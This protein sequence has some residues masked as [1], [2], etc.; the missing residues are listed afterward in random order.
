MTKMKLTDKEIGSVAAII[1]NYNGYEDTEACINSIQ[2]IYGDRL[3]IYLIDNA[4]TDGS[5]LKLKKKFSAVSFYELEENRGYAAGNNLGI[6]KAL[7]DGFKNFLVL[8]NDI[9]LTEDVLTPFL[10]EFHSDPQTGI[11]T[12]K[13]FFT[14]PEKI[15]YSAGGRFNRWICT[16]ENLKIGKADD[17]ISER[18]IIDFFPGAIFLI[19]KEVVDNVGFMKEHFFMYYEDLEYSFRVNQMYKMVYFSDVS[20]LHG[21]GGGKKGMAYS[22]LYLYYHTRNRL[23]LFRERSFF[24]FIYVVLFTFANCIWKTTVVFRAESAKKDRMHKLKKLWSGYF[25]GLFAPTVKK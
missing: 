11:V 6:Q 10:D 14:G 5:G 4:S 12:C 19:K 23:W 22:A 15:I 18:K 20:V 9:I 24:Y 25:H 7:S 13:V 3:A 1:L 17:G 21:C 16:G 8:N 2:K